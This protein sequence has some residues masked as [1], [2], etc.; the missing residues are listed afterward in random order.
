VGRC[1]TYKCPICGKEFNSKRGN[2]LLTHS[3]TG[4][5]PWNKNKSGCFTVETRAKISL[6]NRRKKPMPEEANNER[7]KKLSIA[8]TGV[9]R[10]PHVRKILA[11]YS[12]KRMSD[13]I[14]LEKVAK[15]NRK[16]MADPLV[17]EKMRLSCEVRPTSIE[18]V[19]TALCSKYN[20][21]FK[22]V[23]DGK[24]WIERMNPDF[25]NVNGKKQVVEILGSY[26]H[27]I[28]ET[29]KR[30]SN[31]KKYGFECITIWDN[32]LKDESLVLSKL[33]VK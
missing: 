20:L 15:I 21:P 9:P 14:F 24:V 12:K 13:P 11:E 8:K 17:L 5:I 26:W 29:E 27:T 33:G 7:K 6:G 19:F 32:E 31:F 2:H 30:V 16:R 1:V 28:E 22:Y 3:S 18:K 10:P 23:G 25:I 4:F